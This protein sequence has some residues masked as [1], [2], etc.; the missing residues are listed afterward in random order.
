MNTIKGREKFKNFQIILDSEWSSTIVMILMVKKLLPE[1]D[2]V[3]QWQTQAGK[4]TTNLKVNVYFT[5]PAR[6]AT[7]VVT[8]KCHMDDSAKG[9][10]Y[11]I[12]GRH[13]LKEL[14]SNLNF[15]EHVIEADESPVMEAMAT[16]VD[17][18]AYVFKILN[19]G[20]LNWNNR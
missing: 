7:D 10:Y 1:T 12:L 17:L 14:G 9:R 5:V 15:S 20:K 3:M 19:A 8:W 18:V 13:I 6:I 16:I 11:K 2:A 4:I